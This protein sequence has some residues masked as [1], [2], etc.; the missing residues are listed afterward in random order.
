MPTNWYII[1]TYSGYE[2]KVRESLQS[3]SLLE[4]LASSRDAVVN[5]LLLGLVGATAVAAISLGL[6]YA[7]ARAKRRLGLLMDVV[8]VLLFTVPSTVVGI[9][10][11]GLW[12]RPGLGDAVY[13]TS[14]MLVVG[15]LARFV[16]IATLGLAATIASVPASQEEAAAVSGARWHRSMLHIV[17]PQ[18]RIGILA[19]W[20]V[21]FILAFGEVGTSILVAPPGEST[22]PIRVYTLIANAPPGHVAALAL[23]QS[24]VILCPL[25][26]LGIALARRNAR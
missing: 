20:V 26:L 22:L 3:T 8:L 12:N 16:P 6:G 25:I 10:L 1:H 4:V 13:G 21:C 14:A 5:S 17:L 18:I 2:K 23:F 24:S 15:Y 19:V 9:G 11:I 7:R